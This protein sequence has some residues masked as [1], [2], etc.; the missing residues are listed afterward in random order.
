MSIKTPRLIRDRCGVYYFR[1]VVPAT[2]RETI[3]KI[4]L[5]RSLR[6]KDAAVARQKAL[7][8]SLAV[9]AITVNPK[10]LSNPTL[11]D[12]AHLL[13]SDA[14]I[15]KK[16]TIDLERGTLAVDTLE[17]A[18]AAKCLLSSMVEARKQLAEVKVAKV[19]EVLPKSRA[20]ITLKQAAEEYLS[21]RR[22]ILK[23]TTWRKQRGVLEAF[24]DSQG[25][26]DL[27]MIESNHVGAYKKE[28]LAA[29][30]MPTSINDHISIINGFFDYCI[31]NKLINM[32]NPAAGLFIKGAN[33]KIVSYQPFT[34]EE[35]SRIF[36]PA[37][38]R[39]KMVMPDCYW[40]PLI[41]LYT[42]ARAEEI[43]SLG[44]DD[45]YQLLGI[46]V[47][48]IRGG[49]TVNAQ[50]IV[51]VHNVLIEL[52]WLQYIAWLKTT[53]YTMVFL[54][55]M[56]SHLIGDRTISLTALVRAKFQL[57]AALETE[58]ERLRKEAIGKGFQLRLMEMTVPNLEQT[59]HFSFHF[60][61][62]QYPANRLYAGS[63]EFNKHF[64]PV[65][66]D[67]REKTAAGKEAEEFVC[68]RAIDAHPKVK[69]W[70]RN[71]EAQ[72]KFSF[73]LP[74]GTD[75]FYPDFVA[76]LTDGHILVIEYKGE[77]YKTND[78]SRQKRQVGEQWARAS[79]GRCL[80]LFA[81]ADDEGRSVAQQISAIIG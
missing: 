40:G 76:E 68:A 50:R 25:D 61:P 9:E 49:K 2:L 24:I 43:A 29:D 13:R 34:V 52:G 47:F 80:F 67:L 18:D 55:K 56:V 38:Y 33:K 66:H 31:S 69:H 37:V 36:N 70:V 16:I 27:G 65:I 3:G 51:P 75:Y 22:S 17:E 45:V 12:F 44:R 42:G 7:A 58:I 23:D 59:A 28:L 32:V 15:R 57:V 5:R 63:Y 53:D 64:Y 8:L 20:G 30:R 21:E 48:H 54:T 60:Q 62:G 81:V 4:E 78:D 74:T 41:A 14:D 11:G 6:T 79:N 19:I 77:P 46:W 39:K 35:L 73:W 10:F 1:F 71:I 26:R 72:A